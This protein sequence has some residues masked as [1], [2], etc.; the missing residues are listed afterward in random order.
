MWKS[1]AALAFAATLLCAGAT[2]SA[3]TKSPPQRSAASLEC[4]KQ[5]DAKGLHGKARKS[6]RSKC[7]KSM[8]TGKA[9]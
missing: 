7:L 8:K 4:S 2:A 6:F 3:Q 5:A 1:T 9:A